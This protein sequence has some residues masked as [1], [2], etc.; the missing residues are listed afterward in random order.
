MNTVKVNATPAIVEKIQNLLETKGD[1][2]GQLANAY[3]KLRDAKQSLDLQAK[4]KTAPLVQAMSLLEAHMMAQLNEMGADSI[5]T[6]YGTPYI[7]RVASV[8]VEDA[9]VYLNFLMDLALTH[10]SLAESTKEKLKHA[11][12]ESGAFDMLEARAAKLAVEAFIEEH[13]V[14]PEGLKREVRANLNVR[15]S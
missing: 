10:I 15:S 7:S 11:M 9:G 1:D 8:K 12:V 3:L 2:M 4:E 5:K 13:N 14:L 6:P